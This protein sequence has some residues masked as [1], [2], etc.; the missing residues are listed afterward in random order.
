MYMYMHIYILFGCIH[1]YDR[2]YIYIYIVWDCFAVCV[3]LVRF[4]DP[5]LDCVDGWEDLKV[6][7]G[8][9]PVDPFAFS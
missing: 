4:G 6:S 8:I 3:L 9:Q 1:I 7:I 2:T 5:S